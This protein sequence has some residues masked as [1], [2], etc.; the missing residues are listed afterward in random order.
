M[1]GVAT[2]AAPTFVTTYGGFFFSYPTTDGRA[3]HGAPMVPAL[4]DLGRSD[5]VLAAAGSVFGLL[6][7]VVLLP[8]AN[9][10][11]VDGIRTN[12]SL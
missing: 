9:E 2:V 7:L 5:P 1:P 4:L 10:R 8:L 3:V 6:P 11:I 12:R